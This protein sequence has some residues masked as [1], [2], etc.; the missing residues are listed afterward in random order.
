MEQQTRQLPRPL[1]HR[2][3]CFSV[4]VRRKLE[5][6]ILYVGD[7]Y[8][9]GFSRCEDVWIFV[10]GPD[11][12]EKFKMGQKAFVHDGFE[13]D[14]EGMDFW[15]QVKDWPEFRPLKEFVERVDG[16]VYTMVTNESCLLAVE[17]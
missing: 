15:P 3:I 6:S 13:L 14:N 10:S 16:D 2:I 11:V 4:P 5:H 7:K 1:F 9:G 8:R 12:K 17:E